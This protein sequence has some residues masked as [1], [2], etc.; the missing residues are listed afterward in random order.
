MA[1]RLVVIS[2]LIL[3]IINHC[4]VINGLLNLINKIIVYFKI[5]KKNNGYLDLFDCM[6]KILCKLFLI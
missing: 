1:I 5:Y 2:A 4:I 6:Y 3:L